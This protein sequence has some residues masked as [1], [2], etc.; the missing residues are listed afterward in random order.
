MG[1]TCVCGAE[2]FDIDAEARTARVQGITINE[3]DVLS[4]DG[5]T[6]E[7]FLG[8]LPV[9]APPVVTYLE[10]GLDAALEAAGEDQRDLVRAVDRLLRHADRTRRLRVRAN[11]DTAEDAGH[12]RR[13]GAE[14]IGLTRTEHMFLGER[15]LLVERLILADG[16]A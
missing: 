3:G 13:M 5:S 12:A 11:A 1:R 14:G 8:E 4:I 9:G 2:A 10:A 15:R 7:I 16:R 6:G